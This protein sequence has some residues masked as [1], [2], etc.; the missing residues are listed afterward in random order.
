MNPTTQIAKREVLSLREIGREDAPVVG[1]KA[2]NLGEL[3]HSGITVPAGFA[4]TVGAYT[5]SVSGD[6]SRHIQE[7]L[8]AL[9]VN[10]SKALQ[11][12][13][14]Q[15]QAIVQS[16]EIGDDLKRAIMTAYHA[17]AEDEAFVAVRSSAT[18]EDTAEHSFAGMFESLLNIRGEQQLLDAVRRCWASTFSA[19]VLFYRITRGLPA[20]M[21]VGV[22]VQQ[23]VASEKSG[24]VFTADPATH[25]L[26]HLL[27]EAAWGLGEVVVGGQVTPD[28]YVVDKGS[29]RILER[30]IA[31][32]DFMLVRGSDGSTVNQS[33]A[34]DP[35][36]D[37]PVLSEAEV[38]AIADLSKRIEEHYRVP[39][40]IEFAIAAGQVLITQARPITTL[41]SATA[42]S[43]ADHRLRGLGAS[44]GVVTG[45][46]RVLQS[47][48]DAAKLGTGEILVAP[49]TS[50]EWVPIMKR[51]AGI[52]TDSGGMTSHAAIVAR[53]LGV[54]CIVGT[55]AAT[56]T[57]RDGERVRMNGTTGTIGAPDAVD[58]AETTIAPAPAAAAPIITAT[59][60]YVNLGEPSLAAQV[61]GRDVDGVGLLRAEF[62]MLEA[63]E[64][65]HPKRFIQQG[66]Q[67]DFVQRMSGQLEEFARAFQPRPVIYRSMDFRSNEFRGL[68]GGA[69]AEPQE[70]NPM[71]GFRGC[72][73]YLRE[74]EL[75]R[76][77]LQSLQQVRA[78]YPNVHLMI[79]FVRTPAEFAACKRIVDEYV[80]PSAA[81]QLW[82]MAEVPSVIFHLPA[83]ARLGATGVSIGSNDLT[84]LMLGADRD[85]EL[86][87]ASYD[88]T[89]DAVLEAIHSI[90][91]IS[92]EQGLTC[93]ICGQAPSTRPGYIERLVGWGIDSVSVNAD[94]IEASRRA[95]AIAEQKVMLEAARLRM[96]SEP[97]SH[98]GT[99]LHI[100]S[101]REEPRPSATR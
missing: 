94:A 30:Q 52:I 96:G 4:L 12:S 70:A 59:R 25:K 39:Q 57:L 83:Y 1:G 34:G 48:A 38:G 3:L 97:G 49:M 71:I 72:H 53:E 6:A 28:H 20:D 58:Q 66:R 95:L 50:P 15:L 21:P 7:I 2:A 24:V 27:I 73:R 17:L 88:E 29:L 74:P 46:V 99:R 63:L 101:V 42:E 85:N 69:D 54:P 35:K 31:H 19:R 64:R 93:S 60:L 61:A 68:E 84:Q 80:P 56:R 16:V 9:N 22:V 18:A 98:A 89:D 8:R 92:H 14:V 5:R 90:I 65:V 36:A 41:R 86:L 47:S 81:F 100:H 91:R 44:P 43:A 10:D 82:I 45:V 78:T 75:F 55:R 62:M 33:L 87:A 11:E 67:Q 32:K 13:A 37:E 51:A 26:D 23:M 77:E 79:P 76:L 40:D